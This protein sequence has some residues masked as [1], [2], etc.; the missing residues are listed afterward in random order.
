MIKY[1][2]KYILIFK[3]FLIAKNIYNPYSYI[4]I[5]IFKGNLN[6]LIIKS[7]YVPYYDFIFNIY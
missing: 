3:Y 4:K 5:T 7:F 2:L 1:I 6:N